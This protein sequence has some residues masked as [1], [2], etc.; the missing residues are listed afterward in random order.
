MLKTQYTMFK[1]FNAR[2]L[3]L[4]FY[5][6]VGSLISSSVYFD[7]SPL[8]KWIPINRMITQICMK[9][10]NKYRT[11]IKILFVLV[12]KDRVLLNVDQI[13]LTLVSTE[14]QSTFDVWHFDMELVLTWRAIIH[15]SN[16]QIFD[17][18]M[19]GEVLEGLSQA[20]KLT[21]PKK[22]NVATVRYFSIAHKI[23][24]LTNLGLFK[25]LPGPAMR[26]TTPL[27]ENVVSFFPF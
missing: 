3:P 19:R 5:C 1:V 8:Y 14:W 17:L 10:Q 9:W 2:I 23:T 11:K 4:Y 7:S 27:S 25:P 15:S 16:N 13:I 21:N 20:D 12:V 26:Y 18:G 22:F 24:H 6:C